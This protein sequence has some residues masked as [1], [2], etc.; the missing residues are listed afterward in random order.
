VH[1]QVFD[2]IEAQVADRRPEA[3]LEIGSLDI[4]GSVRPMFPDV[5]LYHGIDLADGPGVDEV[6]DAAT[7]TPDRTYDVVVCAEVLE[8][9]PSW[10]QILAT[11]WAATAPGGVLVMT[12]ACSPRPAHSAVDGWDVRAGE[13]YANVEP[14]DVLRVVRGWDVPSWQVTANRG[15]GDLYLRVDSP[16]LHPPVPPHHRT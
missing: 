15:R 8:H 3:V 2:W 16:P 5:A 6:A 1:V 14:D 12:C 13:H 9:A 10:R 11:M 4:N 7:W